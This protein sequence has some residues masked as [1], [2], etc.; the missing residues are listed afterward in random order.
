[1]KIDK[2]IC[3]DIA[4][5]HAYINTVR[6]ASTVTV[7]SIKA[8]KN[9]DFFEVINQDRVLPPLFG[10]EC[11]NILE[12]NDKSGKSCVYDAKEISTT[13]WRHF[14]LSWHDY[15]NTVIVTSPFRRDRLILEK[16]KK[17][18]PPRS[19]NGIRRTFSLGDSRSRRIF[20]PNILCTT[21]IRKEWHQTTKNIDTN[22]PVRATTSC[23]IVA[24]S[25]NTTFQMRNVDSSYSSTDQLHNYNLNEPHI[26]GYN[27]N[28]GKDFNHHH[29]VCILMII[30]TI[31][32]ILV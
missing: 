24:E 8:T 5:P 23:R 26:R 20:F 31:L 30:I 12:W 13:A 10:Q 27:M 3:D 4:R 16:I 29:L 11:I 6:K 2:L 32:I 18:G 19:I 9:Y 1:M 25:H 15:M 22:T 7:D 21:Y 14:G 28:S 17:L